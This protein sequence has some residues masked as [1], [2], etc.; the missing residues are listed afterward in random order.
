[1]KIINPATEELIKELPEDDQQT[2][3]DK[4]SLLQTGQPHWSAVP[5][6]KKDTMH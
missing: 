3:A 4:F 6:Q 1:M 2:I 5:L